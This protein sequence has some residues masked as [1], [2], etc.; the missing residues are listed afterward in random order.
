MELSAA[1]KDGGGDP[2][3]AIRDLSVAR[4]GQLVIQGINLDVRK[5]SS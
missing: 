4:S 1:Q 2:C 3:P 5:G